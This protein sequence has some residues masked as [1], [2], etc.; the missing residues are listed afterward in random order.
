MAGPRTLEN[1]RFIANAKAE[2]DR[3]EAILRP[4]VADPASTDP[5][6]KGLDTVVKSLQTCTDALAARVAASWL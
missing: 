4:H 5:E 2:Q 1:V 6:V 3:L